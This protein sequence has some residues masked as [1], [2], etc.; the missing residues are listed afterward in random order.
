MA[1]YPNVRFL[2]SAQEPVHFHEDLGVEV[3]FAGRSNSGKSSALNVMTGRKDLARTSK[4]P[5][6]TQLVNFFEL[7]EGRR[8]VDLPGYGFAKVPPAMQQHWRHLIGAY[9]KQ[10]QSLVGLLII[11]DS[12][13]SLGPT[14]LQMIDYATSR[15]CPVHILLSKSDKLSRNEST[16][17]LRQARVTLG[18]RA[19]VQLF[20]SVSKEGVDEARRAMELMLAEPADPVSG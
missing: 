15:G 11:V 18:D 13:R 4:T 8:L 10:R 20:S 14:D 17:V 16:Q 3:A 19:T 7:D 2:K 6:R 12:R 5:G 9:F 1:A